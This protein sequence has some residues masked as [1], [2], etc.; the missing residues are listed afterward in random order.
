MEP[1]KNEPSN[2]IIRSEN[3]ILPFREN[4]LKAPKWRCSVD[5]SGKNILLMGATGSIGRTTLN[6]LRA[7]GNRFHLF[8]ISAHE[9]W[10]HA[11]SIAREFH[12]P[13]IIPMGPV[14]DGLSLPPNCLLSNAASVIFHPHLH[15]VV[16]ATA[17]ISALRILL[18]AME[19]KK[20]ILLANKESVVAGGKMISAAAKR[21]SSKI[22]PVDSEHHAIFQCIMGDG[23]ATF[24]KKSD[25]K[26]V[27]LTASG[28]PFIDFS[29]EELECVS[30]AD[31]I[32]HP[33]WTMGKKISVDSATMANKGLEII[34]ASHLFALDGSEINVLVHRQGIVHC[35][36]EFSDGTVLCQMH[37]PSM[38][39]PIAHGLAHPERLTPPCPPLSPNDYA[40]LSFAL[41]NREQFPCLRIAEH[42]LQVQKSCPCDFNAANEM[43]VEA[44]LAGRIHFTQIA[45]II[46]DLLEKANAIE[47]P[48]VDAVEDRHFY[49]RQLT[50]ELIRQA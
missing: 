4:M 31:A 21:F 35:M 19:A 3:S 48:S 34:E 25:L 2:G 12:V 33:L 50:D 9:N 7:N 32:R 40:H 29:R 18:M 36:V 42:A 16:I 10:D 24:T 6:L 37:P 8:A 20:H 1:L 46:G 49:I 47:L 23:Y 28:G 11:L 14:P 44:F 41:P 38:E 27:T 39:F 15:T 26:S 13:Y 43:T 45:E 17:G 5:E 22:F 30:A